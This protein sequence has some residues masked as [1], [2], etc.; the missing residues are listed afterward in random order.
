MNKLTMVFML[1]TLASGAANAELKKRGAVFVDRP[2]AGQVCEYYID[3]IT[4]KPAKRCWI[5]EQKKT[6]N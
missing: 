2:V 4:G 6:L 5:E 3:S 1:L